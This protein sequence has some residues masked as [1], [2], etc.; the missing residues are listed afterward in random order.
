[1]EDISYFTFEIVDLLEGD[2]SAEL[3]RLMFLRKLR[4]MGCME[5]DSSKF[6]EIRF[7]IDWLNKCKVY[8][9]VSSGLAIGWM[10]D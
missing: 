4:G 3:E 2:S 1:V 5:R 8:P 10:I 9:G 6:E 7:P